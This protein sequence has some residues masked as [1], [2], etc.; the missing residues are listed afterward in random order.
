MAKT[1][2]SASTSYCTAAQFLGFFD[3]RTVGDLCS[4]TGTRIAAAALLT[5]ANLSLALKGASGE[6]EAAVLL[7]NRYTV[8]DLQALTSTYNSGIFLARIVAGL[9]FRD[10][11]RRRPD[12]EIQKPPQSEEAEKIIQAL[13]MGERIFAFSETANAGATEED[14]E[15]SRDVDDRRMV[16]WHTRRYFGRRSNRYDV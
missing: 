8:A 12:L 14:V 15:T 10:L 5:D 1:V 16:T 13:S 2:S 9:T 3:G 6:L 4:D 11:L 7:G